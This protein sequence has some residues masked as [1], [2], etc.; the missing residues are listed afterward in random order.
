MRAWLLPVLM[1]LA[2]SAHAG[3]V[4]S[5]AGGFIQGT[6]LRQ[7][8]ASCRQGDGQCYQGCS[9]AYGQSQAPVQPIYQPVPNPPRTDYQ[10][11][12]R[13]TAQGLQWGLCQQR[14]SY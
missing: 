11:V 4:G 14:C 3:Y 8:M 10:C 1:S 7:C 9:A 13:C 5:F 2:V 12:S 6:A